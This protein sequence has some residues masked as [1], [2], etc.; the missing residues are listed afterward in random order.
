MKK[1]V[2][3]IP[4]LLSA[5]AGTIF[6]GQRYS[7]SQREEMGLDQATAVEETEDLEDLNEANETTDAEPAKTPS[8]S[9]K[10]LDEYEASSDSLSLYEHLDYLSLKND[11]VSLAYYGDI[12]V[13]ESWVNDLNTALENAV[14]GEYTMIDHSHSGLDTYDLY[15][16]Q[17]AQPVIS[18]D[19]DVIVYKLPALPDKLR[20]M[21][22]NETE[23]FMRYLLNSIVTLEDTKVLLLEPYPVPNEISQL[24]SRSLDYRCYLQR[25]QSV[26]EAY[27]VTLIPMH[28]A[29]IDEASDNSLDAYFDD[30]DALNEEGNLLVVSILDAFFNEEL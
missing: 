12:D 9:Q 10:T 17:T 6:F 19:P 3:M 15:I 11:E 8:G 2:I 20:D 28:S 22:L 16:Q 26:A 18:E 25:M 29:F 21:G 5:T 23:E 30:N 7:A 4:L 24:N 27:D 14:S 13:Q 1:S